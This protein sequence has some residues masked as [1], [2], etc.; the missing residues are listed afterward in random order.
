M[1]PHPAHDAQDGLSR[2]WAWYV[3]LPRLA[4][5]TIALA[6][7][8][9]LINMFSGFHRIWFHWPAAVFL[10]IAIL[11]TVS[12]ANRRR[13]LESSRSSPSDDKPEQSRTG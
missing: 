4:S 3:G 12:G 8:M 13:K 6:V 11:W 5:V 7:F 1:P 9:F 10:L 2:A